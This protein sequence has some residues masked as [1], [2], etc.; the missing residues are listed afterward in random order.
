MYGKHVEQEN[1]DKRQ[2]IH[3]CQRLKESK[4]NI[5]VLFI[6]HCNTGGL[7]GHVL[8]CCPRHRP[9]PPLC[10][11]Q[12]SLVFLLLS[13]LYFLH[14]VVPLGYLELVLV[15][16]AFYFFQF[17]T[18]SWGLTQSYFGNYDAWTHTAPS[19]HTEW[20]QTGSSHHHC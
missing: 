11:R 6:H 12:S 2:I 16:A 19:Q 14:L 18:L 10:Q 17:E 1:I 8:L 13:S 3:Q 4:M 15:V 20:Q 5:S 7:R 9:S